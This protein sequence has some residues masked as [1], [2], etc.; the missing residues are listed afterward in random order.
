MNSDHTFTQ[1]LGKITN[2]PFVVLFT[3]LLTIASF[4]NVSIENLLICVIVRLS[5]F[6]YLI[7]LTIYICQRYFSIKRFKNNLAAKANS[8][9]AKINKLLLQFTSALVES[10]LKVRKKKTLDYDHFKSIV[11]NLCSLIQKIVCEIS[12]HEFSVCIKIF[13]LNELLETNYAN[14]S[15]ITIARESKDYVERST[16]DNRKQ[17]IACNTSFKTLLE[18]GEL[19]WSCSD[20]TKLDPKIVEGSSYQNPDDNYRNFYKSTT[21]VPIRARIENV[22]RNIVEYA[23][24]CEIVEYHYL[25]FLCIDSTQ[26][27]PQNE[28]FFAKLYPIL[29]LMGDALYPLF[30]NYLVNKIEG[31]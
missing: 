8:D 28:A 6:L 31:V 1:K 23:N 12:G 2:N 4:F 19:L 20:L 24:N 18:T 26:S 22:D 25:G 11:K 10:S 21:V 30:E 16:Y 15:T 7:V 29:M 9:N 14:M 13:S 27:F 3:Y 5:I 17:S